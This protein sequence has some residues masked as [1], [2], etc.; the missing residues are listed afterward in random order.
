M[1]KHITLSSIF[2]S[3]LLLLS[4]SQSEPTEKQISTANTSF[5]R[6]S[7]EQ[8]EYP[9]ILKDIDV[10]L[11]DD[12]FVLNKKELNNSKNKTGIQ[13]WEK[14]KKSFEAVRDFY[15]ESLPKHNWERKTDGDQQSTPE[16]ENDVPPIRHFLTKFIKDDK[17][18]K[19]RYILLVNIAKAGDEETTIIKTLK[20]M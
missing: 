4:C 18:A 15:L 16:Q 3:V 20:E 13:V 14:S 7:R 8:V 11:I 17:E 12:A 6:E 19:K 10:P 1:Y 5:D 2:L 9:A